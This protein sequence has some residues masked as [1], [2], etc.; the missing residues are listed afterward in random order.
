TLNNNQFSGSIPSDIGTRFLNLKYFDAS[1]N[2][3]S[4]P[5]TG[6]P[7]YKM[8]L[9]SNYLTG[10]LNSSAS[11]NSHL[12]VNCFTQPE[13]PRTQQHNCSSTQRP[14][15]E[16]MAFCGGAN[17]CDGRGICYPDGPSLVPTCLCQP[18]Y[19]RVG[20]FNCFEE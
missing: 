9:S 3:L 14:A 5:I 8:D 18:R 20:R 17:A 13:C 2:Y 6:L 12:A 7:W 11:V 15:A 16:C 10:P 19:L 4:G 1:H